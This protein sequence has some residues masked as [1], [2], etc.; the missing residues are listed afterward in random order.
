MRPRCTWLF[1][2]QLICVK[3]SGYVVR[4]STKGFSR[5]RG[6]WSILLSICRVY[7]CSAGYVELPTYCSVV[8]TSM[9]GV[10]HAVQNEKKLLHRVI[11]HIYVRLVMPSYLLF[12]RI[13]FDAWCITCCS[14]R[15]KTLE[16]YTEIGEVLV[17]GLLV[18]VY[19]IPYSSCMF[20]TAVVLEPGKMVRAYH[21][22][23][24]LVH[25]SCLCHT[26]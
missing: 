25:R 15:E 14:K 24:Y 20:N 16:V 9:L 13:Y 1:L 5:C 8:S 23:V 2:F 11:A 19:K 21:T 17:P 22:A 26:Y 18:V 3:R 10:S 4:S 12:C 6:Y 7:I